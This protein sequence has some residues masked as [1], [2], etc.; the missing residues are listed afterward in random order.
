MNKLI[1]L[2]EGYPLQGKSYLADKLHSF[3]DNSEII[4]TDDVLKRKYENTL[5]NCII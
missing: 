2:I 4:R 3:Y 5:Y 1:I